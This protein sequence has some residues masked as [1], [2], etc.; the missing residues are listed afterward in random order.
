VFSRVS[1]LVGL[2]LDEPFV[3]RLSR[4]L[5]LPWTCNRDELVREICSEAPADAEMAPKTTLLDPMRGDKVKK[6]V[7]NGFNFSLCRVS[8]RQNVTKCK[9]DPISGENFHF[10]TPVVAEEVTYSYS[11]TEKALDEVSFSVREGQ[12]VAIVG[13]TGSGKSTLLRLLCALEVPDAGFVQINGILTT[14]RR[15]RRKL[16]GT[17]GYVMQ[18]P[19][20]QLFA[21][22]VLEDVAFG[23]RNLGL[24]PSEVRERCLHA[25]GLVG[26]TD[27]D[28]ASPFE[29][30]GGQQRLCAIAGILA[31]R[32]NL[33]VLDEPMAGLD[34]RGRR[35]LRGLLDD[36]HDRGVTTIQV[37]HAMEDAVRCDHVIVLNQS[38]VMYAGNPNEVFCAAHATEL[39]EAG[40][41]LPAPL[42][43]ALALRDAG[44][45]TAP[46]A[47]DPLTMDDL[48]E[49]VREAVGIRGA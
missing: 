47:T 41:G 42:D 17:I 36:L 29:L 38:R 14:K 1:E 32:P 8:G 34:P 16:H 23:P 35:D 24:S 37:T 27:L 4:R 44:V 9:K 39:T 22:T 11:R 48:V 25:L 31:M 18:Q 15:D 12:S 46:N 5:G 43:F 33:L 45:P 20:R 26:L 7:Q 28:D 19:E 6:A 13:H 49:T 40:L 3:A 2:G 10:V 30:S 21:E